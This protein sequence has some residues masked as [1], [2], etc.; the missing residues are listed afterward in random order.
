MDKFKKLKDSLTPRYFYIEDKVR[1]LPGKE[2]TPQDKDVIFTI[3][4]KNQNLYSLKFPSGKIT[5]WYPASELE[6]A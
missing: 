4:E 3:R 1:V 5:K 2:H 6:K